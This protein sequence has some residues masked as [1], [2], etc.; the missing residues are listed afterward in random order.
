MTNVIEF[1]WH[2]S[3]S[4]GCIKRVHRQLGTANSTTDWRHDTRCQSYA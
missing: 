4:R 1:S 2:C 3:P